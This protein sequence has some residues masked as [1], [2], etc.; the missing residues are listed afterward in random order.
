MRVVV[1]SQYFHPE[2]V[3]I[4]T[5]LARELAARGHSVRVVTGFPNYPSGKLAEGY[6]Q[7]LRHY[8]D[9][10]AVRVRRVPLFI[11]RSRNPV[12]R[13]LN[14][15]SFAAS[16]LA[17]S[18]FAK[19][20][21]VVYVYA[22]QM[23]AAIAPSWWRRLRGIPFVLHVQD[24]WPESITGSSMIR[25]R[26]ATT[27]VGRILTPWLRG[28]YRRAAATVGISETMSRTLRERGVPA[29]RSHTVYNWASPRS[30]GREP[31][32]RP[33]D[34][35]TGLSVVYAGNLGEL[36]DLDTVVRAAALARDLDGFRLTI[37]GQGV[38]EQRLRALA[39]ELGASNIAFLGRIAPDAMAEVYDD[40]DFQVVSLKDL[41]IFR[42]TIPSKFQESLAFGIPVIATVPGE[43]T[44]IVERNG[45]GLTSGPGDA[46]ALAGVFRAA[47]DLPAAERVA[48]GRRARE[49]YLST[50]SMRRGIDQMEA[51]LGS[52]AGA[53]R[54]GTSS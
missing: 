1:V 42:G 53:D 28:Y 24:L 20:A 30:D 45:L 7:S 50:L 3:S 43:V 23:T 17:A 4:P 16:S 54:K 51:I 21:D 27:L 46:A 33:V 2:N 39:A 52:A 8:E 37:V 9:Q 14:Y 25:G 31:P 29:D 49:F 5:T 12:T 38:A 44:E 34:G 41:E 11:S 10:G 32:A 19:G 13:A 48:M 36:Q 35:R 22:T 26:G 47:Y 15:L 18:G 6:R 40:S